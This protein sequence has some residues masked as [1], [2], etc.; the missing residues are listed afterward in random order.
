MVSMSDVIVIGAG[1]AGLTAAVDLV[2][3]GAAV[4]VVEARDRVGGRVWSHA[5][6]NGQYAER[7]AEFDGVA[8]AFFKDA[9][10]EAFGQQADVFGEHAEQTLNEEVGDFFGVVPA[11]RERAG[12]AGEAAGGV[13]GDVL[14][15]AAG[16]EFFGVGE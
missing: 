8:A 2:A 9:L 4:T 14:H 10:E 15:G 3:A 5:F 16:A 12:D 6:T 13:G 7:G 11:I 1:L